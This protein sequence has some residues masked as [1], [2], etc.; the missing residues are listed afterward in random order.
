MLK[1]YALTS[2]KFSSGIILTN[3]MNLCMRTIEKKFS[4][5]NW[6]VLFFMSLSMSRQRT[7][8][9]LPSFLSLRTPTRL[10]AWTFLLRL[11]MKV[12]RAMWLLA[13]LLREWF[14]SA[15]VVLFGTVTIRFTPQVV[16]IFLV[17]S[18]YFCELIH[19]DN[20]PF[21]HRYTQTAILPV[22]H[23]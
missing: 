2:K 6:R 23:P 14:S 22:I 3:E 19:G 4:R 20:S 12:R 13:I 11:P 8:A 10:G 18:L 5:E 1:H 15:P 21:S 17:A 16:N 7:K 9:L